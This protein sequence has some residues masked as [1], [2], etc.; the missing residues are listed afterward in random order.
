MA[1]EKKTDRTTTHAHKGKKEEEGGWLIYIVVG[2]AVLLVVLLAAYA[3]SSTA[4]T[5]QGFRHSFDAASNVSIFVQDYNSTFFISAEGCATGLI[6][7]IASNQ[8]YHK[9]PAAINFF[10]INDTSCV[11][12]KGLGKEGDNYTYTTLQNCLNFTATM[13]SVLFEYGTNSTA[14]KGKALY[15]TG[16]SQYLTQCGISSELP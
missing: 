1:E 9:S 14:I 3:Y 8:T 11:Y 7:R 16:D 6:E 4:P 13:P 2:L 15:I 12:N 10:V 5:F